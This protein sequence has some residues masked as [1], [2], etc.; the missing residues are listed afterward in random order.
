MKLIYYSLLFYLDEIDWIIL[1]LRIKETMLSLHE[2]YTGI[3][4]SLRN[5][6]V[7]AVSPS[8]TCLKLDDVA[9]YTSGYLGRNVADGSVNEFFTSIAPDHNFIDYGL[10]TT[11]AK[12]YVPQND[13]LHAKL[14]EYDAS[15][16]EFLNSPEM[17]ELLSALKKNEPIGIKL[18]GGWCKRSVSLLEVVIK[19]QH[20]ADPDIMN[21]VKI[22]HC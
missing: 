14:A 18:D 22:Q 17:K 12:K 2:E 6:F 7:E 13:K 4:S 10:I 21:R 16:K 9:M 3:V 1:L 8:P 20:A 19:S 11:L 5:R 15:V